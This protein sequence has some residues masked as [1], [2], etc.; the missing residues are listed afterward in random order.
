MIVGSRDYVTARCKLHK[1]IEIE[2]MVAEAVQ[3]NIPFNNRIAGFCAFT[4]KAGMHAK[5]G[6]L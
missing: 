2:N 4:H 1:L 3:V 6:S 5:Y